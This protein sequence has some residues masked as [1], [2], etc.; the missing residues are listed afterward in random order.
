MDSYMAGADRK[1]LAMQASMR[2][3]QSFANCPEWNRPERTLRLSFLYKSHRYTIG[4]QCGEAAGLLLLQ[5]ERIV[6]RGRYGEGCGQCKDRF[7]KRPKKRSMKND[8]GDL[9]NI[10]HV[11]FGCRPDLVCL[12]HLRWDFVY[13]RPQHLLSRFAR[14]R[15]VFFVE[16]PVFGD[17]EPHLDITRRGDGL[18]VVVPRL[19]QGLEVAAAEAAQK[20]LIDRL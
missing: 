19:V 8:Q 14:S 9:N 18:H 2:S 12:S 5:G 13:Q 15:R 1:V 17:W 20:R 16:E 4:R 6:A 10:R 7:L 11:N 3:A